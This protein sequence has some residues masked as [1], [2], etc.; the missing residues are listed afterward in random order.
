[1]FNLYQPNVERGM[2]R[3]GSKFGMLQCY[4]AFQEVFFLS[5][6]L[7]QTSWYP[8]ALFFPFL[9]PSEGRSQK[10]KEKH[11]FF[12]WPPPQTPGN[13]LRHSRV[14]SPSVLYDPIKQS[15]LYSPS[16]LPGQLRSVNPAAVRS[17]QPIRFVWSVPTSICKGFDYGI[18]IMY[19][20]L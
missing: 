12:L 11:V 1:M 17:F 16:G 15:H 13:Q 7:L 9:D 19:N 3:Y 4:L 2:D 20:V 8:K 5:L 6:F 18:C 14:N 10:K